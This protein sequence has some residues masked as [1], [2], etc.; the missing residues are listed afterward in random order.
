M[1]MHEGKYTK[2][3]DVSGGEIG[4][5]LE[6]ET[7]GYSTFTVVVDLFVKPE[8]APT[9]ELFH[10]EHT[11]AKAVMALNSTGLNFTDSGKVIDAILNQGIVF[12]EIVKPPEV[13]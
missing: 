6:I 7:D 5:I 3:V 2:L 13:K 8:P 9:Q 12:R 1:F 4:N 10:D 11:I